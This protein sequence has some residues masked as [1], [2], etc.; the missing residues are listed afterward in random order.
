MKG[1]VLNS[2]ILPR[3]WRAPA[4]L[5]NPFLALISKQRHSNVSPVLVTNVRI[6]F[7]NPCICKWLSAATISLVQRLY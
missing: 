1:A 6:L 4:F 2:N 3:E 7:T 5:T